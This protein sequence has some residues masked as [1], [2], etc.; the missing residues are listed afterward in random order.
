[1]TPSA[2]LF[3]ASLAMAAISALLFQRAQRRTAAIGTS[4]IARCAWLNE[5][6]DPLVLELGKR[7]FSV[8]DCCLVASETP[9]P[10]ASGF[11][12]ERTLLALEWIRQVRVR[13]SDVIKEHRRTVRVRSDVR[14]ASEL[15]LAFEF[16]TFELASGILYCLIVVRG[17]SGAAKVLD[18]YLRSALELR[19]MMQQIAPGSDATL[20]GIVKP[21][22]R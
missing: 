2:W 18:W 17:L 13:M 14:T 4:W 12:D 16:L 20:M 19:G 7:I 9:S 10:F 15:K 21:I 1:M 8:E 3:L 11:H 22:R 5:E 6:Q